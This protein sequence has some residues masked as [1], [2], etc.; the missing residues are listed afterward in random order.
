MNS[1]KSRKAANKKRKA[2]GLPGRDQHVIIEAEGA[3]AGAAIGSFA[4]PVGAIA[5]LAIGGV[6]GA[7]ADMALERQ[8][9][10][11]RA[12][13]ARLDAA[14]G[15]ID[16]DMGAASPDQPPAVVGAFSSGSAGAGAGPSSH[17]VSEGPMQK[18]G[19]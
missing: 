7:A 2:M 11:D 14:V 3:L 19:G 15:I 16:G 13:E 8:H 5:G 18:G 6:V 12:D 1:R 10:R 17:P 9:R 4:G